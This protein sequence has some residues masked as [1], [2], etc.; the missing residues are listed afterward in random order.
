LLMTCDSF[1]LSSVDSTVM[2]VVV[3]SVIVSL[4]PESV[5]NGILHPT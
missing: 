3:V 4:R 1:N 5:V 2:I